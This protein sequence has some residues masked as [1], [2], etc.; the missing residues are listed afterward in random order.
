[1]AGENTIVIEYTPIDTL[2]STDVLTLDGATSVSQNRLDA[3]DDV[4]EVG[5][6]ANNSTL[7]YNAATDKYVV[8]EINLDGG[9]F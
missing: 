7:V 9:T 2:Q 1:M 3:L 6:P 8:Q 4:E 5:S